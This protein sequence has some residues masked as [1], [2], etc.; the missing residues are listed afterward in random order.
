MYK[1]CLFLCT[2]GFFYSL[3][4]CVI[5]KIMWILYTCITDFFFRMDSV[6]QCLGHLV[7]SFVAPTFPIC[8]QIVQ[9]TLRMCC[10]IRK[11]PIIEP[12]WVTYF[13]LRVLCVC[14][15]TPMCWV[16]WIGSVIIFSIY[17]RFIFTEDAANV[18]THLQTRLCQLQID[19]K[20]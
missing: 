14:P 11:I 16:I 10:M 1:P 4:Y 13:F 6:I 9:V 3:F 20:F 19:A 17:W 12:Y 15:V 7:F 18:V 8:L 5:G 2:I